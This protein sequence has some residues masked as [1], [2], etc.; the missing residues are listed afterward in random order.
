VK[1]PFN[2][3]FQTD[4]QKRPHAWQTGKVPEKRRRKL[5]TIW[6]CD[7]VVALMQRPD[8]I[9]HA[10]RGTGVGIDI[11]GKMKNFLRL[12][13]FE[14]Y[15]LPEKKEDHIDEVLTEKEIHKLEKK[16]N[17]EQRKA[18]ETQKEAK[19]KRKAEVREKENRKY[20]E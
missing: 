15:V 8:M 1:K 7:A 10:F 12:P 2:K 18:K 3:V 13:E 17:E 11:G 20:L 16:R 19:R 9:R 6:T 5:F 14:T 4:F